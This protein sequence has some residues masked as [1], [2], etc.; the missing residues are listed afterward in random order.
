MLKRERNTPPQ[1]RAADEGERTRQ[2]AGAFAA[3]SA[4]AGKRVLL[5]DDVAT[6]CSTLNA[7]ASALKSAGASRVYGLVLAR[8]I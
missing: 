1:A 7:C 4:V 6:T 5:V 3:D 2:V 8:D